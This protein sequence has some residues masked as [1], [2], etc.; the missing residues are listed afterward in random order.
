MDGSLPHSIRLL[1]LVIIYYKSEK[2]NLLKGCIIFNRLAFDNAHYGLFNNVE[3]YD[4]PFFG[5]MAINCYL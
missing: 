3:W 1:Y 2:D 5:I 4:E